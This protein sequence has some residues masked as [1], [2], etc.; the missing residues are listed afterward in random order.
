MGHFQ[1]LIRS[2]EVIMTRGLSSLC[3]QVSVLAVAV[4]LVIS[5]SP[6]HADCI[7]LGNP[8]LGMSQY[9][10]SLGWSRSIYEPAT[11][12]LE[13]GVLVIE[14]PEPQED[15]TCSLAGYDAPSDLWKAAAEDP[16]GF[17]VTACVRLASYTASSPTG[18]Y[19]SVIAYTGGR[20]VFFEICPDSI[21]IGNDPYSGTTSYSMSTTAAYHTYEIRVEDPHVVVSVDGVP[22][23][24]ATALGTWVDTPRLVFGDLS[25]P[26]GTVS[27]W[28]Y[29]AF[30]PDGNTT[31]ISPTSWGRIKAQF[32]E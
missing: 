10:D 14:S 22:R 6:A 32:E 7:E 25:W 17:T 9:P 1:A 30:C 18:G 21:T 29:F 8:Q 26:N 5:S 3:A 20:R 11:I 4:T 28:L 23:L 13:D 27:N 12:T 24:D 19:L 16:A 2:P 31:Q 15:G